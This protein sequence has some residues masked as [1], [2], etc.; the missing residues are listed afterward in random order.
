MAAAGAKAG[1]GG[2]RPTSLLWSPWLQWAMQMAD[3]SEGSG[4][5]QSRSIATGAS[6]CAVAIAAIEAAGWL[7]STNCDHSSATIA[8]IERR[9]RRLR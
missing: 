4:L 9:A 7:E 8:R 1:K 3:S 6:A 2:T 5:W